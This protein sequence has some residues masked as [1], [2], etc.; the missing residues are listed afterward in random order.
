MR[1]VR[2]AEDRGAEIRA[3]LTKVRAAVKP[4][5]GGLPSSVTV[6]R[7]SAAPCHLPQGEGEGARYL[8]AEAL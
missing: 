2:L 4:A 5:F 8:C 3:Q 7:K 6:Q 1:S